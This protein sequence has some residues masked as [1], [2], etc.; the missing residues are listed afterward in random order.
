MFTL[1]NTSF[2]FFILVVS[3]SIYRAVMLYTI[4]PDLYVDEA[5]YWVWSQQFDWGYYS[6]PPMVAWIISIATSLF[7]D[8]SLIIKSIS[9]LSIR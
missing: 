8:G 9:I 3:L 7:G 4:N 2:L 5:Y 6:K 1:R